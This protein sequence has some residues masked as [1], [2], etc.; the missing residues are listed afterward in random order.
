[1]TCSVGDLL[2]FKKKKKYNLSSTSASPPSS[3]TLPMLSPSQIHFNKAEKQTEFVKEGAG[4]QTS[5]PSC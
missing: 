3:L 4:V 5:A 1:M 2:E